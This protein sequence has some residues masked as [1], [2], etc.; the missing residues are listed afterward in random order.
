M[1]DAIFDEPRFKND[2]AAREY[3]ESIRW[4][5]GPACPHCGGA[6][7][8]A[9]LEGKTQRAGLLFCGHCRSQY[10][11][12][13]GTCFERSHVPLHK[14]VLANHLMNSSKKGMSSKQLER[15]LGVTYKTAWFMSHRIR[16]AMN[17]THP[18]PLGSGG[19][20][21]EADETYWGN[22]GKQRKGARGYAHKMKVVSL[23]ERDGNKRSF[24]VAN[25]T[26]D[27]V[28]PILLKHVSAQA[29]LMTDEASVYTKVGREFAEHGVVNHG[30]GEYARGDVTTNTVESGFAIF[31]RG[32]YG[33]FHHVSEAH[34]QRYATE[35]DFRWNNRE[36]RIKI[37][38]K[39][40]K[41]GFDDSERAVMALK[42][43]EGKRLTYRWTDR[44]KQQGTIPS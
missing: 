22:T 38:G 32:L 8:Q 12:T 34:L 36:R 25:V 33:T 41:V 40:T 18:G 26:A 11:V 5:N 30:A 44:E 13:V 39:W 27:I 23:V 14:W 21:V 19:A 9:R 43:I 24:H 16:E 7:R 4:P 10:T 20:P 1:A 3:L 15:V 29:R 31:K 42:G 28:R 17:T 37:D 35:F 6:D 2:E